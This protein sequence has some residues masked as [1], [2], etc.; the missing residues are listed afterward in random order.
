[1][2]QLQQIKNVHDG[3]YLTELTERTKSGLRKGILAWHRDGTVTDEQLDEYLDL[4]EQLSF[5]NLQEW[6]NFTD[7][8]L[9]LFASWKE[10]NSNVRSLPDQRTNQQSRNVG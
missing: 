2:D 4:L 10:E 3:N 6:R 1:M 9:N 8:H 5:G 7:A